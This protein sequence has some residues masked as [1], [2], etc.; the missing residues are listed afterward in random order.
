MLTFCK[1]RQIGICFGIATM[2]ACSAP[3][4]RALDKLTDLMDIDLKKF[5]RPTIIDNK[6]MPLK[7]GTQL[8]FAGST[9]DDDGKRKPHSIV[10]TV[11]DLVKKINGIDVVVVWDRDIADGKLEESE[12]TFFA[13]DDD[14][15]VWHLGQ[16]R[17]SY[18][19]VDL[20]GGQ[21]WMVGHLDGAKAG[22]M[23]KADPKQGTPSYSQGYA[24]P[25]FNWT[26]RGH[27]F[28]MA[29]KVKVPAGTYENVLVTEE[30][31]MSEASGA[32]QLKYYAPGVG[33]IKVGYAGN[34]EKKEML[35][36]VKVV[37]LS[38][39]E[40]DEVRAEALKLEGR[41]YVY[42]STERARRRPQ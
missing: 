14:G 32:R 11:T 34:D 40:M 12:L 21:A 7:P 27:V 19:G 2:F 33:N 31:A 4:A 23:M 42:C 37:Q 15:N 5:T 30:W 8:V 26:D 1:I 6:W 28:K 41:N 25:P 17:E 39:K 10:F 16:Y 18:E 35:D 13:Q 9:V 3:I 24:P 22:I 38:P 20:N 36:L 29:Q